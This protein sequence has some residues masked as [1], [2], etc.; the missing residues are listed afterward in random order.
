M[1]FNFQVQLLFILVHTF[2][3]ASLNRHLR[4]SENA[5]LRF[6]LRQVGLLNLLP[7]LQQGLG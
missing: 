4:K 7:L 1:S 3:R 2:P 5:E 6:Q